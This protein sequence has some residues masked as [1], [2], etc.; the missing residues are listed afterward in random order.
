MRVDGVAQSNQIFS[1][2]SLASRVFRVSVSAGVHRIAVAFLNDAISNGDRNLLVDKVSVA[3]AS[4]R[5]PASDPA[6][7]PAPA[8]SGQGYP[9]GS[10]KTA[11]VAGIRPTVA[12]QAT[13]DV[14]VQNL[15]NSW[16]NT[17]VAGCGGNYVKFNSSYAAVSEG[18]SYGMLITAFMA[19]YDPNARSLFDGLFKF[20]RA[21]P[22]YMVNPNLMDWRVNNDCSSAGSGYNAIDG[23]LD[24]AMGLLMADRQWGS[25]GAIN[26]KAEAI[27]TINAMKAHNMSPAGYTTGGPAPDISRTSDYMIAHFRS[28]KKVTGDVY[29]D[30]VIDKSFELMNLMQNNFAGSTGLIPD[31]IVGLPGSPVPSPGNRIESATEGYYAWNACRI[32]LRLGADYVTS[33][34]VRSR[35]V[36]AKL[37]DF[38][39]NKTGG[40]SSLIAM[41]Y[42]LDGTPLANSPGYASPSFAGPALAGAL[43]DARFQPFVNSLWNLTASQPATGYYDYELQL[44]SMIV[45]S[46]NWWNP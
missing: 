14:A 7:A 25:T 5:V 3:A 4:T 15:Y 24:I 43:V 34:D 1:E 36:A 26:Y 11:Y 30:T 2:T 31:F 46:G 40:N 20:A 23:D 28:F 38:L 33:G 42:K 18:I 12:T 39:N 9:F 22:A 29:W 16:K 37:I 21:H 10:R 45:A 32:P 27:K 41:G 13:Q 35:D 8:L 17:I 44:L 6:P 19:G